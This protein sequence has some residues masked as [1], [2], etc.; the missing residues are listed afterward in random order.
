MAT[1]PVPALM[2]PLFAAHNLNPTPVVLVS[3]LNTKL[4]VPVTASSVG[5]ASEDPLEPQYLLSLFTC[6]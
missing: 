2:V 5:N 6:K 1:A 3:D 4:V